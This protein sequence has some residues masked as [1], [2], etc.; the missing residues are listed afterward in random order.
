MDTD[1]REIGL[2]PRL[3][4]GTHGFRQGTAVA[5]ALAKLLCNTVACIYALTSATGKGHPEDKTEAFRLLWLSLKTGFGL[6]IVDTDT[7]LDPLRKDPE[8]KR[9]VDGARAF[10]EASQ[11]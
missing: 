5:A 10:Y 11:R 8:F 6:D 3:H 2:K 7:D 9:V 4:I 1:T